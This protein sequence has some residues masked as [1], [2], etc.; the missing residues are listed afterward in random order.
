MEFCAVHQRS[1]VFLIIFLSAACLSAQTL[2]TRTYGGS[3]SDAANAV[4]T[5]SAGNIYVVGTTTSFDLPL[6][7]PAQAV[8]TGTQLLF[9]PDA[10]FTWKPLGNLP[11]RTSQSMPLAVDPTNPAVLY[12]ASNGMLFKSTDSGQYFSPGVL[13]QPALTQIL[14]VVIDPSNPSTLYAGGSVGLFKSADGGVTW[15]IATSG[16]PAISAVGSLAIDP[17]HPKSLWASVAGVGFM[18]TDRA[19]S[20]S[21][22]SLPGPAAGNARVREFVFDSVKP[23]TLYVFGDKDTGGSY[24]LKSTD[25]GRNWSQLSVPFQSGPLV[26]DP[27]RAG[28]LYELSQGQDQLARFY[29]SADGGATWRSFPFPASFASVIAIDPANPNIVIVGSYRSTDNGET[30][31]PTAV[32]RDIQAAFAPSGRGAVY[33]T[34]P[35]TSDIFLAKFAPDGKTLEFA[36]Y[37]GA[38]GNETASG[39]QVDA[40]GN[41]W[42][43]GSTAS[44]DLPV[45]KHALQQ[46]LKGV[47]NAFLAEF[48]PQGKLLASTYLGGSQTDTIAAIR[49][50]ASGDALILGRTNSPDFPLTQGAPPTLQPGADYVFLA[51]I[52]SSSS[53]LLYSELI[54][55]A[56]QPGGMSIDSAGNIVLTG[57]TYSPDFPLTAGVVHGSSPPGQASSRAFLIKLDSSGKTIFSTYLGGSTVIGADGA[58]LDNGVAVT[59]DNTGIYV[60]GNTSATDFP[61]TSGAYQN[62]LKAGCQYPAFAVNTGFIGTIYTYLY[63]D[64]F[65]MKLSPDAKTLLYSTLLGGSCYDRPTDIAVTPAGAVFVTGETDSIDFPVVHPKEGAPAIE[66]Y[67]SFVSMIS[68]SGASLTYSSYLSAGSAP[69]VALGPDGVLHIAGSIGFDAQTLTNSGFPVPPPNPLT[70]AYLAGLSVSAAP[71]GLDL[72]GA[73]NAFS[74]L[75]GPIAPGEIVELAVPDFRPAQVLDVGISLRLPLGTMLGGTEVLF[76]GK[77]V[78][79]MSIFRGKIVCIAPPDFGP[80]SDTTIQV[81]DNGS[82]SN[83]LTVSVAPTALGL[84]S[85]DGSGQGLANARN[86]DGTLNSKTNPAKRGTT[87]TI[88]FTGAGVP[89]ATVSTDFGLAGI[90]PLRGFVPGIYAAYFEAPTDLNIT[91]PLEVSLFAPVASIAV[92]GTISQILMVYIE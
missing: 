82:K 8:N 77:P 35:I 73:L 32:S 67:K 64:V 80:N 66:D 10:G 2:A 40:S 59:T 38:M 14:S 53:Q 29:R 56:N 71:A 12:V 75:P 68:A 26:A 25:G 87:V 15:S 5:D 39:V 30:W 36:T 60:T 91:S 63:D 31:L 70:K 18:S 55:G 43:A 69:T 79:V 17:F 58:L 24:L 45:S 37:F 21:Q 16:L 13:L 72:T 44:F 81:N 76:D 92:A 48:S 27:V 46:Q 83:P 54:P 9:S 62:K 84:L 22:L 90:A 89:P 23:G 85:A 65:V 42:V 49:L 19:N 6:L 61:V 50:D 11:D 7:N 3:G 33:A 34:A 86:R 57:T 51:K 74:L 78:P 1:S 41:I 20:W 4:T 52:S 88:F 47:T 28:Y